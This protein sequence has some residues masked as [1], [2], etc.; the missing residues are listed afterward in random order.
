M[1]TTAFVDV[2]KQIK[3]KRCGDLDWNQLAQQTRMAFGSPETL[4]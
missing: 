2:I 1:L 3:K 4:D